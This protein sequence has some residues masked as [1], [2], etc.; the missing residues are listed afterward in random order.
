M[1]YDDLGT[2]YIPYNLDEIITVKSLA[3]WA[4][5]DGYKSVNGFYYCTESY[6]LE[7]NYKLKNIFKNKFKL[8]C[9]IHKHTNG[10]R[11]YVFSKAKK[12]LF[13]LIKPYLLTHFYYK[14]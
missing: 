8:E 9:G 5:D 4:M 1:F 3:Y 14:F 10:H 13:K 6:I 7:D 11:L 12:R 2:K